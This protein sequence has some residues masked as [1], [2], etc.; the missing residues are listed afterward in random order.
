MTLKSGE[1]PIA[2]VLG[3]TP[4]QGWADDLDQ[5]V[6][7]GSPLMDEVVFL[8]RRSRTVILDDLIQANLTMKGKRVRNAVLKIEGAAYPRGGVGRD[9]KLTFIHRNLARQ[10]LAKLLSWDFD[11]LIIAHG[12]CVREDA[13]AYVE[14]AFEWLER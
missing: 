11:K 4:H 13:K 6:F 2:G 12:P 7:K 8:H 5:L 10:S 9:I 14:R 1:L 3:D